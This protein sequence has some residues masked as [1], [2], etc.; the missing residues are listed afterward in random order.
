[1]LISKS[2]P[3]GT[4]EDLTQLAYTM[5]RRKRGRADSGYECAIRRE[6]AFW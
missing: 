4:I 1:M 5:I 6:Q 2:L 3:L